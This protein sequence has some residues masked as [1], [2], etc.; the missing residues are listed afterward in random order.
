MYALLDDNG[1]FHKGDK[2]YIEALWCLI[3]YEGNPRKE[4]WEGILYMV[5]IIEKY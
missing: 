5:Q 3:V 1:I 2:E 4:K